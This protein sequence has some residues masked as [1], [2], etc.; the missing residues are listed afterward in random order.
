MRP[1][2]IFVVKNGFSIVLTLFLRLNISIAQSS[3]LRVYK[4]LRSGTYHLW[5]KK[6][7]AIKVFVLLKLVLTEPPVHY[8]IAMIILLVRVVYELR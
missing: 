1:Q 3:I 6:V 4:K 7:M 5:I 8:I 2:N